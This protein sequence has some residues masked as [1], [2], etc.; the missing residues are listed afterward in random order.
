MRALEG[1]KCLVKTLKIELYA[2]WFAVKHPNTP[3]LAKVILIGIIIYA[4]TPIDLIPDFIPVLGMVD[5]IVII[6]LGSTLIPKVW[7]SVI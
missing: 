6:L 1:L 3:L 7:I 4:L 5:D 2:M